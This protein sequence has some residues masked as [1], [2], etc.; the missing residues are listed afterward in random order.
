MGMRVTC[1]MATKPLLPEVVAERAK[2]AEEYRKA[3]QSAIDRIEKL[4][5]AR[6]QRDAEVEAVKAQSAAPDKKA[7]TKRA[8]T[9][10]PKQA[11]AATTPRA[12]ASSAA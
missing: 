2:A 11:K 6:M 3:H 5:A 9:A 12:S 7:G 8:S 4:R 10:S 1:A